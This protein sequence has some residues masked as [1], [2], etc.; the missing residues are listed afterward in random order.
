MNI[1]QS[2]P[3]Q[4]SFHVSTLASIMVT[5]DREIDATS[6]D[7]SSI[8]VST[9]KV[10]IFTVDAPRGLVDPAGT[11][12]FF[13]SD[14]VGIVEG[15]VSLD[16]T[17]SR[18]LVFKPKFKFQPNTEYEVFIAQGIAGKDASLLS[19]VYTFKFTTA[20]VDTAEV[21]PDIP[22]SNV[23]I[24]T[25]VFFAGNSNVPETNPYIVRTFPNNGVSQYT[26]TTIRFYLSDTV[27]VSKSDIEITEMDVFG[28]IIPEPTT[29]FIFEYDSTSNLITLTLTPVP[30]NSSVTIIVSKSIGMSKDYILN[31]T[32]RLS[33][34]YTTARLV[35]LKCG[36]L[37]TGV[38]DSTIALMILDASRD[39]DD[40]FSKTG[41]DH[42]KLKEKF[43]MFHTIESMLV[44]YGTS[45]AADKIKKQ[46]AEFSIS[47]DN[48]NKIKLYNSLL[49]EA[50]KFQDELKQW[51]NFARGGSFVRGSKSGNYKVGINRSWGTGMIPGLNRVVNGKL[52]WDEIITPLPLA[53][54]MNQS[55]LYL[56]TEY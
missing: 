11:N 53:S 55:Y 41:G 50:N 40:Y 52:V 15:V 7:Q 5:F 48:S 39:V 16:A 20:E 24:G 54:S 14:F 10:S 26:G 31:F 29:D 49:K 47:I 17:N 8:T 2:I 22:P 46:L 18:I 19:T 38:P 35:K 9:K 27:S 6:I 13:T 42:S 36:T 45:S 25:N 37:L 44:S 4:N 12:E 33:P 28:D 56:Q 43:V 34:Y 30:D 21:L 51:M 32:S 3:S 1:T 23:I